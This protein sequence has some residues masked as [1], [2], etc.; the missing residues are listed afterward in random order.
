MEKGENN[1]VSQDRSGNKKANNILASN[2]VYIPLTEN[3]NSNLLFGNFPSPKDLLIHLDKQNINKKEEEPVEVPGVIAFLGKEFSLQKSLLS[4]LDIVIHNEFNE[5][6]CDFWQV[7]EEQMYGFLK[8]CDL[9][10]PSNISGKK[11]SFY[12]YRSNEIFDTFSIVNKTNIRNSVILIR[13][14]GNNP[15][16]NQ[17][18]DYIKHRVD[19]RR[20][21][22]YWS[23]FY[24]KKY[25]TLFYDLEKER[26]DEWGKLFEY[27]YYARSLLKNENKSHTEIITEIK[28]I[29]GGRFISSEYQSDLSACGELYEQISNKFKE[30]NNYI[31]NI[32]KKLLINNVYFPNVEYPFILFQ[33]DLMKLKINFDYYGS[34]RYFYNGLDK[35][36]QLKYKLRYVQSKLISQYTEVLIKKVSDLEK[37]IKE[38]KNKSG[39]KDNRYKKYCGLLG[40]KS[41]K[42]SVKD[43]INNDEK[44]EEKDDGENHKEE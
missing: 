6:I 39:I 22:H 16:L 18:N 36:I 12:S 41:I 2:N 29:F 8:K 30:E 38:E 21:Y 25:I 24:F 4:K 14:N 10:M 31:I 11:N 13:E 7:T 37:Y 33:R 26:V 3:M 20:K 23:C 19:E 9:T 44:K 28:N 5:F 32:I 43:E 42:E 17:I 27:E 15:A 35:N 40:R 34:I 1:S